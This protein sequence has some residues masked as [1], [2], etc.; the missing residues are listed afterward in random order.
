MTMR[1]LGPA[2]LVLA[3]A[4]GSSG[5]SSSGTTPSGDD[6]GGAVDGNLG[7][8]R[9]GSTPGSQGDSGFNSQGDSG[10]TL[11]GDSG[12]AS[13]DGGALDGASVGIDGGASCASSHLLLCEDFESGTVDPTTW[14][15]SVSGQSGMIG[16]LSVDTSRPYAGKY[17]LYIHLDPT[18]GSHGILTETRTFPAAATS[19]F[20]RVW[21][22]MKVQSPDTHADF[23]VAHSPAGEYALADQYHD[24]MALTQV[25]PEQGYHSQTAVPLDRW[26]CLEWEFDGAAGSAHYWVDGTE[27]TDIAQTHWNTTSFTSFEIG[28]TMWGTDTGVS[29]YDVW[30]DNLGIDTSRIGCQ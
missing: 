14:T 28:L 17:S 6:G 24:I 20:G 2:L 1:I 30:Y 25:G 22:Y 18:A 29:G 8:S 12:H 9:D 5:S 16:T 27:L 3:T 10:S 4:C 13:K 7:P 19:L 11:Q 26:A 15:Q 23:I 21:F